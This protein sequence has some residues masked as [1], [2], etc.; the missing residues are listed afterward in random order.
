MIRVNRVNV[1][2]ILLILFTALISSFIDNI[3]VI[4]ALLVIDTI[5]MLYICKDK[6]LFFMLSIIAT[7]NLNVGIYVCMRHGFGAPDWQQVGLLSHPNN[8]IMARC[9][10]YNFVIFSAFLINIPENK[11]VNY[12]TFR[13]ALSNRLITIGGIILLFSIMIYGFFTEVLGRINGYT[14]VELPLYEYSSI[15]LGLVWFFSKKWDNICKVLLGVFVLIYSIMFLSIGDRSSVVLIASTY[16]LCYYYHHFTKIQLILFFAIMVIAMNFVGSTRAIENFNT[17]DVLFETIN[18]GLYV[19]TVTFAY[20][21][22]IALTLLY[23]YLSNSHRI[24]F[25]YVG[26]IFLGINTDMTN[27]TIFARNNYNDLFNLGGGLYPAYFYAMGGYLGVIL[28]AVCL[29]FTI[30]KVFTSKGRYCIIYQYLITGM[31]FRWYL[32]SFTTLYKG[33]LI[34]TTLALLFCIYFNRL[35]QRREKLNV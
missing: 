15:I 16:F 29:G 28:G 2:N 8:V 7:I 21:T 1:I 23:N 20:Y 18:R 19:D 14:S 6:T 25:E 24:F 35:T 11:N 30:Y 27:L 22:S 34:Y 13:N 32:Y 31:T 5:F 12:T 4:G 33:G 9:L 3:F 17:M 10:L 26:N